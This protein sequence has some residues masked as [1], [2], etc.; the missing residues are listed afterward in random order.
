MFLHSQLLPIDEFRVRVQELPFYSVAALII[1]ASSWLS[2]FEM[3]INIGVDGIAF[4]ALESSLEKLWL[5]FSSAC[6]CAV[7]GH[8]PTES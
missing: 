4:Q 2:E 1:L 5:D 7:D 8:Q 3:L 6:D